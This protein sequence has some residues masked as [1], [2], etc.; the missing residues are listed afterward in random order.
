[1]GIMVSRKQDHLRWV[2]M[3]RRGDVCCCADHINEAL[4]GVVRRVQAIDILLYRSQHVHSTNVVALARWVIPLAQFN[5]I[6]RRTSVSLAMLVQHIVFAVACAAVL[7]GLRRVR[8]F[9]LS[10]RC[11]IATIAKVTTTLRRTCWW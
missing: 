5:S 2:V 11:A 7:V 8:H 4:G 6:P 1:M 3:R 10:V 9:V